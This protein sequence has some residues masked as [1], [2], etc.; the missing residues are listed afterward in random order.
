MKPICEITES[1][2]ETE[3]LA[4]EF[5]RYLRKQ[6]ETDA[7]LALYGDLGAGKTAFIRGLASVLTPT[8]AVCSPTYTVVNEYEENGV[9]LCHFDMYRI[10]SEEDLYSIGFFEY[11]DCVMAVEWSEHIPFAL[12]NHY[13][14][15]EIRKTAADDLTYSCGK[16]TITIEEICN[17]DSGN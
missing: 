6:G 2:E 3:A 17:E 7:F 4:A 12:P 9:R 1:T 10:A 11:Q 16:R 13:Y 8:A 15:I 5:A 14:R